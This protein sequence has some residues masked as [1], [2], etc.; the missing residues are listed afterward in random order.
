M[1]NDYFEMD[2]GEALSLAAEQA[3]TIIEETGN[4]DGNLPLFWK[5]QI[6]ESAKITRFLGA[7]VA[8]QQQEIKALRTR[9]ERIERS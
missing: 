2:I 1:A 5:H 3:N 6:V 4:Y 7:L 8:S 9:L